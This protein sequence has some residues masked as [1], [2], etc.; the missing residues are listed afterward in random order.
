MKAKS[1]VLGVEIERV[2]VCACVCV[3]VCVWIQEAEGT[4]KCGETS[5]DTVP[6]THLHLCLILSYSRKQ[7]QLS[8]FGKPED[9]GKFFEP[10]KPTLSLKAKRNKQ[11]YF[12]I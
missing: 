9:G 12:S 1:S 11:T 8:G 2:C 3:C 5:P 4:R 7:S 6:C 10:K